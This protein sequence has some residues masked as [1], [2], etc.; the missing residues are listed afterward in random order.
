MSNSIKKNTVFNAIKTCSSILFPLITIPYVNRVLLPAN[1]GKVDFARAFV[2]YFSLIAT[3]GI[4][5]YAI[6]ECAA[7]R[8]DKEKLNNVASQIFSI[9]VITTIIAYVLMTVV[10]IVTRKFDNYRILIMIQSITLIATTMGAD[11]INSG[12][13]DFKYITIRSMLFQLISLVLLFLFVHKESDY[14]RYLIISVISTSGASIV[15]ARY[16]KKYCDVKFTKKIE[17]RKHIGPIL[18]LFVM[19]LSQVIFHNADITMLGIMKGDFEV[20]LYSTA[21]K[22]TN[23]VS[24]VVSSVGIVVIPRLSY[25]FAKDDFKNANSLLRKLLGLNIG[26]GLP[27]FVGVIMMAKDISWLVGG[28][29][30]IG[31]AP[32]MRILILAFFF[33]LV[34]GNFLGN[35]I[36]IATK[37]E[38]YYMIVC[39]ITAVINV[40]VNALLIPNMGA[41][42]A[43]IATALN[44]LIILVLLLFKVDSRIRITGVFQLAIAPVI[45]CI[46][47]VVCCLLC[48][49]ISNVYIRATSSV[50]S[51][52]V[53][54]GTVMILM[55]NEFILDYMTPVLKKLLKKG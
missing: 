37:N 55:K 16:R 1:V 11:W 35:A 29:E 43:A 27:S 41:S 49:H 50:V 36:L 54:Y 22:I 28:D 48:S 38:K 14:I 9:N 8:D 30:F 40:I 46:G 53:V 20:G 19:T 26:L 3:L 4:T 21:H 15:N 45:G 39:C 34:G 2:S 31:A 32:V 23:L 12:M 52:V 42:G 10:M 25:Y 7:A 51:S 18:F 5:T 44:G 33:S 47:I 13:E 24:S 6:R 17:W